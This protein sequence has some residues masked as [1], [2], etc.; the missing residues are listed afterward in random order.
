LAQ[1]KVSLH[2]SEVNKGPQKQL[3]GVAVAGSGGADEGGEDNLE[4]MLRSLIIRN[5][6]IL[7][8]HFIL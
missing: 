5:K 3:A 4:A 8:M 1:V 2:S 7:I 6:R